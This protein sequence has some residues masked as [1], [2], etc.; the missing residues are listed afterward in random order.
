MILAEFIAKQMSW[1]HKTFGGGRRTE[2]MIDHITKELK[3]VESN[4][5]SLEERCDVIILALDGAWRA[6]YGPLQ[7]ELALERKQKINISRKWPKPTKNFAVEHIRED[8]E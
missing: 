1:S 5:D 6:G 3:E 7:I 4:P 2:G 8:D